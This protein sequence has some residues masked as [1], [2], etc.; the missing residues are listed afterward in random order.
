MVRNLAAIAGIKI[1]GHFPCSRGF[2]N[3][4]DCTFFHSPA[5]GLGADMENGSPEKIAWMKKYSKK[6]VF[7][8]TRAL[9]LLQPG[10]GRII[11][12]RGNSDV[13]L[14]WE[15][16]K[17]RLRLDEDQVVWFDLGSNQSMEHDFIHDTEAVAKLKAIVDSCPPGDHKRNLSIFALRHEI[18]PWAESFGLRVIYDTA[19][20]RHQFA[21]KQILHPHP[22]QDKSVL[23]ALMPEGVEIPVP[24]GYICSNTEELLRGVELMRND[25]GPPMTDVCIK[26][27]GASDGD[28]IEFVNLNDHEK[29][30]SYTFPMGEV[31][32]EEK[33]RLDKNPDG[34]LMTIVS[35]FCGDKLL[36]PSCDQLVGNAISETA[37][38]GN[39]HPTECPR[40]LRKQCEDSV[41]AILAQTKPQG[42]GGF[43]FLFEDGKPFLVD[44]NCARFNGGMYPKAFHKQYACRK[45]AYVSFKNY[46]PKT[47]LAECTR[48]I[49]EKGWE[50]EPIIP[51]ERLGDIEQSPHVG[52]RGVFPLMHLPGVC[53][54]YIAIAPTR[55]ECVA[56]MNEFVALEL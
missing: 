46:N 53:G 51:F 42:P 30:Q 25:L 9:A 54:S 12:P 19:E 37:F 29:F 40:E 7:F 17:E 48:V 34:T 27:V 14:L 18:I 15:Y 11:L 41:L 32:I 20:W 43:D 24:R 16:F 56:L 35:H 6:R 45:T 2:D 5:M 52:E 8:P 1:Y 4:Q 10:R 3:F 13:V 49:K 47:T 38:I 33:L 39:I 44:V 55:P 50:F 21:Y 22:G 31:A 28:G 36:G 26:P 23:Q